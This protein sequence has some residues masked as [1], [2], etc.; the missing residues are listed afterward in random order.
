VKRFPFLTGQGPAQPPR[1]PLFSVCHTTAR[2]HLWRRA[3]DRWIQAAGNQESVEYVLC[4]DS[5]W[6]F[7][8]LGMPAFLKNWKQERP[9]NILVWNVG[10]KS[11]VSG[12]NTAA[13]ASTGDILLCAADD[14]FP[15][16]HWDTEL[17][18]AVRKHQ[19]PAG[20]DR[21][22]IRISTSTDAD[23]R[24]AGL[25]QH[26]FMSRAFYEHLGS[27]VLHPDYE[28]VFSD[29]DF[30][31]HAEQD[32]VIIEAK[33]LVFPHEHP[34]INNG[35]LDAAWW[36]HNKP[37]NYNRGRDIFD[38]RTRE[39]FGH[40]ELVSSGKMIATCTPGE[41]FGQEWVCNWTSLLSTLTTRGY[42]VASVF[43]GCS[44]VYITRSFMREQVLEMN[45]R[46]QYVLWID[47]DNILTPDNLV[48]LL[49]D[50]Q[51]PGVDMVAAW[52]WI[53]GPEPGRVKVSGG[54]FDREKD[55]CLNIPKEAIVTQKGLFEVEWTGFPA[56]LMKTEMLDCAT[57]PFAPL[58][59][60][61]SR[62]GFTGEDISFCLNARDKGYR[63]FLDSR[64]YVPHLK[65]QPLYSFT[66]P[67]ELEARKGAG[68][69][70]PAVDTPPKLEEVSK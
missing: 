12:W 50:I 31:A 51:T 43:S 38:R 70:G 55:E 41:V 18:E 37:E 22:A 6:G 21:F 60:P 4:V 20:F 19:T 8:A 33:G 9:E 25:I 32:G 52:T 56:V 16:E 42:M 7:D 11:C 17:Y 28:G 45:P 1:R 23:R 68:S 65:T 61:K 44:N 39:C 24:G 54:K 46:P 69:M 48:H 67:A 66:T 49:A 40:P 58:P 10:P 26:A 63:I 64:V 29:D 35:E 15:C 30:T 3:Y 47:D 57:R 59:A 27:N 5:R 14:F 34:G 36:H 53:G 2:P 13:A 62:W